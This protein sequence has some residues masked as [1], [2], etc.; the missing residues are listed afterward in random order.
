[1]DFHEKIFIAT[2]K[3]SKL[4][5]KCCFRRAYY[6][7]SRDKLIKK[8]WFLIILTF[9]YIAIRNNFGRYVNGN[10]DRSL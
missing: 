4:L 1:M 10:L 3:K 9:P 7:V 6:K 8:I 5:Y 2:E